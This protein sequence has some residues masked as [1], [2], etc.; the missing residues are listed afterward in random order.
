[1]GFFLH[2]FS[3][4]MSTDSS[5]RIQVPD[6]L[7]EVLLQFSISYLVEQPPDLIDFAADYFNK[8]QAN[9]PATGS[10]DNTADDNQSVNSQEGDGKSGTDNQSAKIMILWIWCIRT[11]DR[12]YYRLLRA[13]NFMNA[14]CYQLTIV[15]R[16]FIDCNCIIGSFNLLILSAIINDR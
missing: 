6:E 7:K 11:V 8:L 9:R 15:N 2:F 13:I 12:F 3:T 1:M 5:R 16:N 14:M 4:N 10:T